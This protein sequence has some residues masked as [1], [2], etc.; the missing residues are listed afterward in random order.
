MTACVLPCR[1]EAA[2]AERA[3]E[4]FKALHADVDEGELWA[5]DVDYKAHQLK[6]MHAHEQEELRKRLEKRIGRNGHWS[7]IR[8]AYYRCWD[9]VCDCVAPA[10]DRMVSIRR[11]RRHAA[12]AAQQS[13]SLAQAVTQAAGALAQP[14]PRRAHQPAPSNTPASAAAPC[15]LR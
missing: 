5:G 4:L 8:H 15:K 7:S 12:A 11:P 14:P 3:S 6:Q 10:C 13:G 9:S 2:H 1:G